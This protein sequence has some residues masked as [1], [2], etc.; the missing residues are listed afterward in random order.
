ARA[1][2]TCARAAARAGLR[3]NASSI[4]CC[5]ERRSV[6]GGCAE[7]ATATQNK[8]RM[9][10][11]GFSP[12]RGDIGTPSIVFGGKERQLR[13]RR[14]AGAEGQRDGSCMNCEVARFEG[15][16]DEIRCADGWRAQ[17]YASRAGG[18]DCA[19]TLDGGI[20]VGNE[21][22]VMVDRFGSQQRREGE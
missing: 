8:E 13:R 12:R 5:R 20:T 7:A 11:N 17:R 3:A 22:M 16:D 18:T 21:R 15:V 10:N 19:K 9:M 6:S 2:S 1:S 14:G 4:A